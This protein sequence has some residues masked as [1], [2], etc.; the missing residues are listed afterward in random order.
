MIRRIDLR[1]R[2]LSKTEYQKLL[3]RGDF[4]VSKA[5]AAI[6]PI[7]DLFPGATEASLLDLCEKFDGVRPKS[8]KVEKSDIDQAL[9]N[10]DPKVKSALLES[11]ARVRKN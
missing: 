8:L 6:T 10:L 11:I 4:D 9:K 3:P 2:R 7:L 5:M 1:G